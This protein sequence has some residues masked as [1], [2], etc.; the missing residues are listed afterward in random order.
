MEHSKFFEIC[1]LNALISDDWSTQVGALVTNKSGT[2]IFTGYNKSLV[3]N[4]NGGQ[5]NKKELFSHAEANVILKAS[6]CSWFDISKAVLYTTYPPCLSCARE[7]VSSKLSEIVVSSRTLM[8]LDAYIRDKL[9]SHITFLKNQ[10]I[11]VTFYDKTLYNENFLLKGR[12]VSSY[13]VNT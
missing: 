2:K 9:L 4:L 13:W 3:K 5:L 11:K 6:R 1:V 12:P 10:G 8:V 7:I